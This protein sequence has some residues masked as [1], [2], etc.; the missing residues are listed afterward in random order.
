[1][2]GL[3]Y[4]K[5]TLVTG[6]GS[7]IGRGIADRFA[8]EGSAIA[9]VDVDERGGQTTV[10][11]LRAAGRRA[12]FIQGDVGRSGDV[13][14]AVVATVAEFGGLDVIVSNAASYRKG[15]AVET[16][17]EDWDRTLAVC[18]K[19]T[20]ALAHHGVPEMRRRGGGS[21]VVISSVHALLGYR[22]H[23]AYQAAKAGLVGLTRA[24]AADFAPE[25]RVNAILPGAVVT[26]LWAD[27]PE[28]DRARIARECPLRRNADPGDIADPALFLASD[29][30]RYVTATTLVVDGGLTGITAE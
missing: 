27:V 9:V 26:G 24:L 16:G 22:R 8:E 19:A 4:G 11:R 20:W 2:T 12:E 6:G 14:A 7:G 15:D 25:V 30:A 13:A 10:D 1:M 3:L 18:L 23:V 17:E 28:A 29:M 5:V 21:M